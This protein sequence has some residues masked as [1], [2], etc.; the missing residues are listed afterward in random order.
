MKI[1]FQ[2]ETKFLKD[3]KTGEVFAFVDN[4]HFQSHYIMTNHRTFVD[5]EN[6]YVD[7]PRGDYSYAKLTD[8]IVIETAELLIR[9]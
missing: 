4:E 8:T 9:N 3:A 7:N 6:G 2:S 1:S 5:L